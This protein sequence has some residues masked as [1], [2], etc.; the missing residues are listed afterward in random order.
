M[1]CARKIDTIAEHGGRNCTGNFTR[2]QTCNAQECQNIGEIV[3]ISA[4]SLGTCCAIGVFALL[5]V[6]SFRRKKNRIIGKFLLPQNIVGL[7]LGPK[8]TNLNNEP[9]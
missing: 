4:T 2:E 1:N 9:K 7:K 8:G 6:R 5:V 3:A